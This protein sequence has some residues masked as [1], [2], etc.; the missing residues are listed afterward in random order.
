MNISYKSVQRIFSVLGFV[1]PICFL[2][3]PQ[4]YAGC[5][6]LVIKFTENKSAVAGAPAA[7]DQKIGDLPARSVTGVFFCSGRNY[8]V[9]ERTSMHFL[10]EK[11]GQTCY[12]DLT[13]GNTNAWNVYLGVSGIWSRFDSFGKFLDSPDFLRVKR[14][15]DGTQVSIDLA[16]EWGHIDRYCHAASEEICL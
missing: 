1:L 14:N 4:A 9:P 10:Y 7:A 15:H 16:V 12:R 3:S 5:A 6:D 11:N 2:Q 8:E 13:C